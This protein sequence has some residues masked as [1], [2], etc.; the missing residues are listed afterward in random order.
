MNPKKSSQLQMLGLGFAGGERA[1]PGSW[2]APAAVSGRLPP[3][4][5]R[6]PPPSALQP[7]YPSFLPRTPSDLDL[8]P[9]ILHTSAQTSPPGRGYAKGPPHLGPSDNSVSDPRSIYHR[10]LIMGKSC[11]NV[12]S[13]IAQLG[14]S[15]CLLATR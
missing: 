7:T 12:H 15:S 11:R 9:Y 5:S 14:V 4:C 8:L 10:A 6:I 2:A 13:D 1:W 3:S